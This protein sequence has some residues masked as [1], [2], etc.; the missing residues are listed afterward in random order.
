MTIF[1]TTH[2]MDEAEACDRVAIMD[3][4]KIIALDTPEHLKATLGGDV[5]SV[6]GADNEALAREV[7]ESFEVEPHI[8][9]E[10]VE[11]NVERGG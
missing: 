2:Y 5:V 7:R 6:S 1:L 4:G 3:Y 8:E 11:F 9:N 10:A